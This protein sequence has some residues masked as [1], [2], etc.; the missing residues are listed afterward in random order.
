MVPVP[1]ARYQGFGTM[2]Q[3]ITCIC[4]ILVLVR[5]HFDTIT[6]LNQVEPKAF[7]LEP[8]GIDRNLNCSKFSVPNHKCFG[9]VCIFGSGALAQHYCIS[10]H[11]KSVMETNRDVWTR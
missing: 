6:I 9:S 7:V 2:F 10:L 3:R 4:L 5:F 8:I 11:H 1:T